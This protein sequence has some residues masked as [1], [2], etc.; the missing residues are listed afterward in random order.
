[1]E[2]EKRVFEPGFYYMTSE[3]E[4]EP[5]LVHCYHSSDT[6]GMVFGF[7]THDGGGVLP[8][9]DVREDSVITPVLVVPV[10]GQLMVLT[11][12]NDHS[13]EVDKIDCTLEFEPSLFGE[14]SLG[15]DTR[16]LGLQ[17]IVTRIGHMIRAALSGGGS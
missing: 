12:V 10:V 8:V 5:L 9:S 11:L 4:P 6:G 3:A 7:N 16:L 2:N 1:M 13:S 15:V 17:N 14:G